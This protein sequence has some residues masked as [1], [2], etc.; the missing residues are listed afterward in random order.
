[1]DVRILERLQQ[2]HSWSSYSDY[3][4]LNAKTSPHVVNPMMNHPINWPFEGHFT[5]QIEVYGIRN[6]KL[7]LGMA[8][9]EVY[10]ILVILEVCK[11]HTLNLPHQMLW[12]MI[13]VSSNATSVSSA[14]LQQ[15]STPR[16]AK[17]GSHQNL[18]TAWLQPGKSKQEGH[19]SE[20]VWES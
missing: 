16:R 4:L 11:D 15:S 20:C 7:K 9:Y 12:D 1:M 19:V 18:K 17:E 14:L 6:N 8:Y 10:D 5:S 2:R 3:C 13:P